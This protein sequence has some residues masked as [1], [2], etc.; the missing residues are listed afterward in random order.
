MKCAISCT[1]MLFELELDMKV[2]REQDV[3]ALEWSG[4]FSGHRQ[5]IQ[6]TYE[7]QQRGEA[8]ILLGVANDFPVAQV[9]L[10][11]TAR[12]TSQRPRA[13]ALRVFPALQGLGIGTWMLESAER[14]AKLRGA[15]D[16]EIG[17]ETDNFDAHRLYERLGYKKSGRECEFAFQRDA[18]ID[19]YVLTKHL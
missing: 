3:Q 9:W 17:V 16:M 5:I 13:W 4:L 14:V 7:R 15:Q 11:F 2:C 12:G 19:Q 18:I 10:D 8:L 1:N 6:D